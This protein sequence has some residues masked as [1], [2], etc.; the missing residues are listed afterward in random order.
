MREKVSEILSLK[1]DVAVDATK[2]P[3]RRVS[4]SPS[5]V[6]VLTINSVGE[7][8][9]ENSVIAPQWM[10][11]EAYLPPF[12]NELRTRWNLS[13]G[14]ARIHQALAGVV[15]WEQFFN[16]TEGTKPLETAFVLNTII[17]DILELI[18][19]FSDPLDLGLHKVSGAL[20]KAQH[21]I[22]QAN[23]KK[24]APYVKRAVPYMETSA[25]LP[26]YRDPAPLL[27]LYQNVILRPDRFDPLRHEFYANKDRTFTS[28]IMERLKNHYAV[29][30]ASLASS[31]L[32]KNE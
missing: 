16:Q 15:V 30:A 32:A 31:S 20:E 26:L 9:H 21:F 28:W 17:P 13:R 27:L 25:F 18:Q 6:D 29:R 12:L 11:R 8:R 22:I 5:M 1:S 23:Q 19:S 14:E 24:F 3:P 2:T 10:V 4:Y 7:R